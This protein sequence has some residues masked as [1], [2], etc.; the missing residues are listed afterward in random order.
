MKGGARL[1]PHVTP[2]PQGGRRSVPTPSC[3]EPKKDLIRGVKWGAALFYRELFKAFEAARLLYLVV[4]G[5]AVNL[6]GYVR[7]TVDLDIMIDLSEENVERLV[8][9]MQDLGYV[10]RVPAPPAELVSREK[11]EEWIREKGAV[12]FTFI[13]PNNMLK[14]LDIFLSN[15]TDFA[16]AYAQHRVFPIGDT[17]IRA[18]SLETLI[19]LKEMAGRPRDLEDVRHLKMIR[20]LRERDET[21]GP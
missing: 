1:T 11:R 16:E 12:V 10:P 8:L 4:G 18:V 19:R 17:V 13:D 3:H 20:A 7:M 15:P 21:H 2:P 9:V 5:L 14:H 6:Y